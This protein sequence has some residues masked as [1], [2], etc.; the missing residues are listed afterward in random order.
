MYKIGGR[1]VSSRP[2]VPIHTAGV[3]DQKMNPAVFLYLTAEQP[4][5]DWGTGQNGLEE[6]QM[7]R[8]SPEGQGT[9]LSPEQVTHC[10]RGHSLQMSVPQGWAASAL[11]PPLCP[12][13]SPTRPWAGLGA[14]LKTAAQRVLWGRGK[15]LISPLRSWPPSGS[16]PEGLGS[17][18]F[19]GRPWACFSLS[20]SQEATLG[21]HPDPSSNRQR[22]SVREAGRP[23]VLGAG[24]LPGRQGE[25][26]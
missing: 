8:L 9:P 1:P 10:I 22:M 19:T 2:Q 17:A 3:W 14:E 25:E 13:A 23:E 24:S 5:R 18:S 16:L 21:T 20:H 11:P 15:V 7:Q 4:S 12:P 6:T 26:T